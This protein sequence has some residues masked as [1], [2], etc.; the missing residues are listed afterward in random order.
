MDRLSL[1]RVYWRLER[2]LAPRLKY[3]QAIFEEELFR[4]VQ[5]G[6]TWLDLGCGRR[7]LPEWREAQQRE[8][9]ARPRLLAGVDPDLTSLN[10]NRALVHRVAASISFL[11][12]AD[13]SFDIVTANMV[14]EH[15]ADPAAQFR[16]V[17]RVLKPGGK[18]V[19]HT[20]N[21]WG[22]PCMISRLLPDGLKKRLIWWLQSRREEDVFPTF[23][24][25]NT[26][27]TIARAATASGLRVANL[28]MIATTAHTAVV[29]PLAAVELLWIR[30]LMTRP[31]RS[32]RTNLIVTLTAASWQG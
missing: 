1:M 2:V 20:E 6:V 30:A 17:A 29:P 4:H 9:V 25:A 8:L 26:R 32:L 12:F 16:E 7:L 14:V 18:F 22:Y 31:L 19:F 13:A 10:D 5:S 15:L 24:R 28:R 3:S 21:A 11:P 23:Y 27:T